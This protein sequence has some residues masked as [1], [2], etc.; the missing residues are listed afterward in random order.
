VAGDSAGAQP[1]RLRHARLAAG[2]GEV[3]A[4]TC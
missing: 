4:P 2:A 1:E 3:A